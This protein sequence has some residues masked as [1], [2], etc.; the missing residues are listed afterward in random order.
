MSDPSLALQR[1]VRS[2]L[3]A[4]GNLTALVPADAILATASRPERFPCV[5]LRDGHTLYSD[6]YSTF[7][8]QVFL[9]LHVWADSEEAAKVIAGHVNGS[10]RSMPFSITGYQTYKLNPISARYVIDK[11]SEKS[12][13]VITVE[14]IL[15]AIA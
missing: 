3:I 1:A 7:F 15:K 2:R 11:A 13:A 12:H 5:L 6:N 9:D 14:A 4:D 10:I 8:E